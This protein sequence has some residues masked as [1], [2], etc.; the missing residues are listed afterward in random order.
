MFLL[1]IL[2]ICRRSWGLCLIRQTIRRLKLSFIMVVIMHQS[3]WKN[4]YVCCLPANVKVFCNS[5]AQ[6]FCSK[7][8]R[9]PSSG[10]DF[11]HCS[12]HISVLRSNLMPPTSEKKSSKLLML[13]P[14][15]VH[16]SEL[17][18]ILIPLAS[19]QQNLYDLFVQC[20]TP[21]DGQRNCPKHV[22][23]YSKK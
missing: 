12:T 1:L 9:F 16:P 6:S 5:I 19:S 23:F 18:S 2:S 17:G 4:L 21:D 11:V 22:G 7:S 14:M 8:H 20:W 13:P 10:I 15:A 3:A